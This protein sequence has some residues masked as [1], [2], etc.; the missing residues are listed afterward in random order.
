M[1]PGLSVGILNTFGGA[2][3]EEQGVCFE[4][5]TFVAELKKETN[6]KKEFLGGSFGKMSALA[7]PLGAVKYVALLLVFTAAELLHGNMESPEPC[8][9]LCTCR[10]A[11]LDCSRVAKR[12]KLQR[13]PSWVTQV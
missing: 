3:E 1:C 4:F 8:P 10:G 13:L 6:R 2:L 5:G 7:Q 9:S 12:S 11:L